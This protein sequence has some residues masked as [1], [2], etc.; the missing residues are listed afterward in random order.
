MFIGQRS[1]LMAFALFVLLANPS[2]AQSV[3]TEQAPAVSRAGTAVEGVFD[4]ERRTPPQ[5]MAVPDEEVAAPAAV[6][7]GIVYLCDSSGRLGTFNLKTKKVTVIGNMGTVLTDIG[8]HP[9]GTLYG[10]T[11]SQ[12]YRVNPATAQ[13]T[14][15]GGGFGS[16]GGVNALTFNK[17]GQVFSQPLGFAASYNRSGIFLINPATGGIS[18]GYSVTPSQ[19]SAG[20]FAFTGQHLYFSTSNRLLIDFDFATGHYSS[21]PV[22]I[23]NL[24]GLVVPAAGQLVGFAGTKAYQIN[25]NTGASTVLADFTNKGLQQI[26]GAAIKKFF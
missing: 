19:L 10:L 12:F 14:K 3:N 13:I 22:S 15:V 16:T 6:A 11:F 18:L 7:P 5:V 21:H 4:A 20:D 24:Y 9:N 23:V 25:P 17:A 1:A 26:Y 8:F 2:W